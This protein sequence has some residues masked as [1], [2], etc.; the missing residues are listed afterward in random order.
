[1]TEELC[2]EGCLEGL[3]SDPFG[4]YVVQ[5]LIAISPTDTKRAIAE[6]LVSVAVCTC[7]P[8]LCV[9]TT[10]ALKIL[11]LFG[12]RSGHFIRR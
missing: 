5:R 3:A 11:Q 6:R 10:R 2:R 7:T 8:H 9:L 4:N 12:W 1:M